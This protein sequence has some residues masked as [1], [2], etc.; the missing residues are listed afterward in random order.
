MMEGDISQVKG[1]RGGRYCV[2]GGPGNTSC[3]NTSYTPGIKMLQ[4][5][6]NEEVRQKWVKFVQRHRP[7]FRNPSKYS[8]LCSAH[9]EDTSYFQPQIVSTGVSWRGTLIKGSIPTRDSVNSPL[10]TKMSARSKRLV[11][12]S[13]YRYYLTGPHQAYSFLAVLIQNV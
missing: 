3:K 5:P 10:P 11:S 4:F 1:K 13:T 6:K 7:S 2:A 12:M 9:F 8:F